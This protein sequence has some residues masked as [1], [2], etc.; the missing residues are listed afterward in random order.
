[1]KYLSYYFL[2]C[3]VW[4]IGIMPFSVMY[5]VSD[6]FAWFMRR[7]LGYRKAV[8]YENLKRAFPEHSD[9][10][11]AEIMKAAYRNLT[12]ITLET[13]KGFT[14]PMEKIHKRCISKN[15]ELIH[16]AMKNGQSII[17]A[18]SHLASWE[19]P[20]L[21]MPDHLKTLVN[22]AY[23]P[24]T[25]PLVNSF[26]NKKRSKGGMVMFTMDETY[27]AMRKHRN[28]T[29]LFILVSDQSPSSRKNAHWTSFFGTETA[30][31]PGIDFLAR[32]FDYPVYYFHVDRVK[33]GRYEI[34]Y[35]PICTNPSEAADREITRSYASLVEER[36]RE[37]PTDWLWS[38]KR[39]KMKP[40]EGNKSPE[41]GVR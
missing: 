1:M 9:A 12:D 32:R 37:N 11:I 28:T 31:L 7:V 30:F 39:W 13:I 36:I 22:C 33:R 21:V 38:H 25:N 29:S 3:V 5:R 35:Y 18:G 34:T 4:L 6:A 40:E 14:T 10:Q 27:P 24:L 17:L 20:G 8:M 2:R 41:P 26:Y 19:W 23:K 15:P 16:E